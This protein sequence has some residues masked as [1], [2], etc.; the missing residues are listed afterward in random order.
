ML[1]KKEFKEK[2]N[3]IIIEGRSPQSRFFEDAIKIQQATG[4]IACFQTVKEDIEK[5]KS[6]GR[7][8]AF[9]MMDKIS[10]G[11]DASIIMPKYPLSPE[12]TYQD[13]DEKLLALYEKILEITPAEDIVIMGDSSGGGHSLGMSLYLKDNELPQHSNEKHERKD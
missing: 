9:E 4:A 5:Q 8:Y 1:K 6:D 7:G 10:T 11:L 2:S 13:S 12:Y 3:A